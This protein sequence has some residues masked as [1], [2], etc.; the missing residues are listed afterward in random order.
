MKNSSET[1]E[2]LRLVSRGDRAARDDIFRRYRER[3]VRQARQELDPR[4]KARVDASD[5]AQEVCKEAVRRMDAYLAKRPMPFGRWLSL[6]T[7]QSVLAAF[8]RHIA[9]VRDV[10]RE[11]SLDSRVRGKH[12]RPGD[13]GPMGHRIPAPETPAPMFKSVS[14]EDRALVRALMNRLQPMDR[15]VLDLRHFKHMR[16]AEV[17]ARLGISE[18]AAKKRHSRAFVRLGRLLRAEPGRGNGS[19]E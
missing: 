3:L 8:R 5:I 16:L 4:L 7:R 11:K 6:L 2:L 15:E 18:E 17:A 14:A 19:G 1:E 12:A 13:S 9:K 10:R